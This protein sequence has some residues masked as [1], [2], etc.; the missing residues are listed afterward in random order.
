[1]KIWLE[2]SPAP[3]LSLESTVEDL[4]GN[5][6]SSLS[7]TG[8]NI[9]KTA[10]VITLSRSPL[11][12]ANGWNNSDVT[13]S[14]HCS[15]ALAGV[16]SEADQKDVISSEGASQSRSSDC[17]DRAG[18]SASAKQGGISID[19]TN[20]VIVGVVSPPANDNSVTTD[21]PVSVLYSCTDALST[22]AAC[23][24]PQDLAGEGS[25]HAT[26]EAVDM[27]G[28]SSKTEINLNIVRPQLT[29][30]VR[31]KDEKIPPVGGEM[32]IELVMKSALQGLKSYD[33]LFNIGDLTGG[34]KIAK[35]ESIESKTIDAKNFEV[36]NKQDFFV[37]FRAQDASDQIAPG[38]KDVVFA[39]IKLRVL[40]PGR[41]LAWLGYPTATQSSPQAAI[42]ADRGASVDPKKVEMLFANFEVR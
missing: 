27:A 7:V 33:L 15:D 18:N 23:S 22:I 35:I 19:K 9:D 24:A 36:L 6:A 2:T 28:N 34:G 12:N 5:V 29:L 1:M 14:F 32:T 3:S 30:Q 31:V 40:L 21:G 26:G 11:P 4:A 41:S 39:E 25:Q 16:A 20:P 13:L 10:P 17:S 8:I 42:I 37:Q 38:A